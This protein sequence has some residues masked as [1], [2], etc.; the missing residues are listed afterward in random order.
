MD[1]EFIH[2]CPTASVKTTAP[3]TVEDV[4]DVEVSLPQHLSLL[5]FLIH[6]QF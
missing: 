4:T 3:R 1:L 2:G 5:I 6:L